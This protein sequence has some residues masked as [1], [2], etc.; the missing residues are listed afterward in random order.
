M[1]GRWILRLRSQKHI[2][3]QQR[4]ELAAP[5]LLKAPAVAI[6]SDARLV[7]DAL[8][9]P[10]F[11]EI[12]A[13]PHTGAFGRAYH[14]A[15][16][17]NLDRSFAVCA[18]GDIALVCLC[19]PVKGKLGFYGMPVRLIARR[20]L[21]SNSHGIA[22]RLAYSHLHDIARTQGA[23]EVVIRENSTAMLS[24]IGKEALAR[25]GAATVALMARVDL[26]LGLPA[27]RKALRRSFRSLLNWGRNNLS[28]QF[29]N[30][31]NAD[32]SLFNQYRQFHAEVAG[33]V[34]RSGASWDVMYDWIT[35]GKGELIL[36][37]LDAKLVTGTLLID[38][39][40]TCIYASGVNDRSLF[41]KPL[42]H[43]PLWLAFERA[44]ARGMTTFE[45]G[46]IP[47]H[48][49]VSEK[50]YKIGYFKRGF[51]TNIDI[52]LDWYWSPA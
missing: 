1:L 10:A 23:S 45:L 30:N 6:E 51:A 7:S 2:S 37:F 44:Q 39:T 4:P 52:H 28:V 38:G 26:S 35:R 13:Y 21:D 11:A 50:E 14:S 25:G 16:H 33:R 29:I 12:E 34:T 32:R 17:G 43:Y 8:G 41:D 3:R 19:A 36:G 47:F 42:A 48:G 24:P 18:K 49:A 9:D 40:R 15:I 27:W 5:V 20:C 22:V 31:A 46:E